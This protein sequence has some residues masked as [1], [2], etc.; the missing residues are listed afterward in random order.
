[1]PRAQRTGAQIPLARIA[2]KFEVAEIFDAHIGTVDAWVRRGCPVISRGSRGLFWKFNILDV[3][4]WRFGATE[5]KAE[6]P[7]K[8]SP[9][10]R[11]DWYRGDRER[12][13]HQQEIGELIPACEYEAGLS[14]ALKAVAV[15]L[16]SLPD[17]LDRD[18]GIDGVAVE[19]VQQ[20]TDMMRE[21]LY[22][23]IVDV[24]VHPS[25]T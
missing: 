8:M 20:A 1:M 6:D 11:L 9:K 19:L 3:A 16:E 14:S 24:G 4:K 5:E 22:Q 12:T 17:V 25:N 21:R 13:R 10:D 15:T 23:R 18:A 7:E 2:N